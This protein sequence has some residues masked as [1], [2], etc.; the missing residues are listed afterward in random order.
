MIITDSEAKFD[1]NII[2]ERTNSTYM[3]N[4]RVKC[5]LSPL[6]EIK[7]DRMYRELVGVNPHL[8]SE[9]VSQ[10]AYAL[11]QLNFR[12]LESP[13]FWNQGE[14]PGGHIEDKNVILDIFDKT[15]EA[16]VTYIEQK[17]NELVEKQK[18]L[19]EMI[20]SKVIEKE[21][22]LEETEL[23]EEIEIEED[24]TNLDEEKK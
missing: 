7:A 23:V 12:V 21:P 14:I 17:G 20:K 3:G 2:G 22:E 16:Q 9:H 8:A 18:R 4:F 11:S 1:V 24:E 13:P 19:A 6:E 5:I 10:M 15:V